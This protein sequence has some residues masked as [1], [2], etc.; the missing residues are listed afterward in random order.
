MTIAEFKAFILIKILVVPFF[1]NEDTKT[2]IKVSIFSMGINL[3]LNLILIRE[4][5]HVGLAIATSVAAWVNVLILFYI[6]LN[7]LGYKFDK[8]IVYDF[9]KILFSSFLMGCVLIF[10][11][12][13]ET[14]NFV[15]LDFSGKYNLL[16][17]ITIFTGGMVYLMVSHFIGIRY[18]YIRT[19]GGKGIK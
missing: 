2:P 7:K 4:F 14:I 6:L 10:M 1:A 12:N 5:L 3:I 15:V 13:L 19:D 9:L 11:I 17:I 18:I 8:S 16:L